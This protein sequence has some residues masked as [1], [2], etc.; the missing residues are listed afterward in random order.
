MAVGHRAFVIVYQVPERCGVWLPSCTALMV[1]QN[2]DRVSN[3]TGQLYSLLIC[4]KLKKLSTWSC[5][6]CL[7]H[8]ARSHNP[9]HG[10]FIRKRLHGRCAGD[11]MEN[12]SCLPLAANEGLPGALTWGSKPPRRCTQYKIHNT[13]KSEFDE[14]LSGLTGVHVS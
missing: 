8:A 11:G 3:L 10:T 4:M 2:H 14:S 13:I 1:E 6:S 7:G 5:S 9:Q 12:A